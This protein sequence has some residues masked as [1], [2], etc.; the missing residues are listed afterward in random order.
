MKKTGEELHQRETKLIHENEEML[1][2]LVQRESDKELNSS[3][4]SGCESGSIV[5]Q[6]DISS[7][8]GSPFKRGEGPTWR[9]VEGRIG[10]WLAEV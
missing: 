5:I 8:G 1:Q 9:K 7:N 6:D 10:V 2:R 4:D 3:T